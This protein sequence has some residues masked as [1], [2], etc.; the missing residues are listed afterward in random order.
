MWERAVGIPHRCRS[1]RGSFGRRGIGE[2]RLG[3]DVQRLLERAGQPEE[4]GARVWRWCVGRRA[5]RR[6]RVTAVLTPANRV[7]L[8]ASEAAG[9]RAR[10]IGTRAS[11][12]R[13]RGAR[14]FGRGVLARAA[15]GGARYVYGVRRGRVSFVA[16]ASREASATPARLRSYLRLAGLR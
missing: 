7:G 12:A 5:A 3:D 8:V 1:P 10:R 13:V 11:A 9:H 14:P 2:V 15:G 6:V 4:R 16:V